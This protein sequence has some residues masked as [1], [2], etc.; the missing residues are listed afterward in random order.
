MEE[1]LKYLTKIVKPEEIDVWAKMHNIIPEKLELFSDFCSSLIILVEKT[2][3][4]GDPGLNETK[5][6]MT[7]EDDE[8]HFIWCWRKNI[9]NFRKEGIIFEYDGDHFDYMRSF[10]AQSF[11]RDKTND[12]PYSVKDFFEKVFDLRGN[13]SKSDLD[14]TLEI[15]KLLE[16]KMSVSLELSK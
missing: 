11:Y 1:F 9:E 6:T 15:Y 12:T 2:Y 16:K 7:E 5:I 3:L 8:R 4:G 10:L 13:L 14:T